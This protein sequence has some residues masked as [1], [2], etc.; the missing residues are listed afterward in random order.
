[1]VY[2][3]NSLG[4]G[5]AELSLA[6]ILPPLR[7]KGVTATVVCF[8]QRD[9]GVQSRVIA[10][11]FDV[12]FVRASGWVGRVRAVRRLLRDLRP[13]ILHT[14][15]FEA[16]VVCVAAIGLD[17]VVL[18]SLVNTTYE[19]EGRPNPNVARWKLVAV[20]VVD[21]WTARWLADHHHA[22]T[23]AVRDS[24]VRTLAHRSPADHGGDARSG[25]GPAGLSGPGEPSGRPT[26]TR[27]ARRGGGRRQRRTAGAP[28]GA[29]RLAVGDAAAR[30]STARRPPDDRGTDGHASPQIEALA[31][32]PALQGR[33]RL[34]GHR[35]DVAEVLAAG[36]VFAFPSLFEGL[37]GA[38]IEAMALGLPVVATSLPAL[39]EVVEDGG[40]AV[41]VEPGD[42][43]QLA[44]AL[45]RLLGDPALL[46]EYG[47]RS[48][49]LFI[50]QLTLERSVE[51]MHELYRRL[52]GARGARWRALRVSAPTAARGLHRRQTT[53]PQLA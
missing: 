13:H 46:A 44:E 4:A 9:E 11:G 14:T 50:D 5:G 41:L 15:I 7:D 42:P 39:R 37:G 17:C 32:D 21:G 24:A 23:R 52:L 1:M 25:R 2:L 26:G 27:R 45:D 51:G 40:N 19:R 8:L 38:V 31:A 53:R 34:L 35:D 10:A 3:I 6:E 36:D 12:R 20:R 16:D 29:G 30:P 49:T 22:I 28:E 47:R 33:V 43:A 18:T 48:R